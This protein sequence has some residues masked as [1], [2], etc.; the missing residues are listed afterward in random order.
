MGIKIW[1][2]WRGF[3]I[4]AI[5]FCVWNCRAAET[6]KLLWQ[7]GRTD[8]DDAEFALAPGGFGKFK[9]D[10]VFFVGES[11][12]KRDWPYAQPGPVDSWGGRRQHTFTVLFNLARGLDA[13][14]CELR[15]NLVDVRQNNPPTLRIEINGEPFDRALAP[16]NGDA[17]IRGEAKQGRPQS[18]RISFPASLLRAG[19]ND[20][21]ITTARGSWL[22]YDSVGMTA[23]AAAELTRNHVRTLLDPVRSLPVLQNKDGKLLQ[24]LLVP[25]RHFAGAVTGAIALRGEEP[26]PV[27]LT[28]GAQTIELLTLA[29]D[30]D[31]ARTL[32]L[33][34]GGQTVATQ[35][36]VLKPARKLTIYVLP[37]SHNDIGYTVI[38]TEVEKK[39]MN[40]LLLGMAAAQRTAS[41]P[42]GARFVW[43]MEV[44]WAADLFMHRMSESQRADFI[45]AVRKG[46]VV[47]N[48]S[49]ANELTGLCRPE[50]LLQLFRYSTEIAQQTGVPI[51]SAMISDVPGYTWG[52]VTAMAQAGIKYFSAAPNWFDR[53]GTIMRDCENRPFYWEAPDGKTKVLTWIPFRGYA[54]S[55][56]YQHF[57]VKLIA[58]LSD[59]LD[60]AQFPYDIVYTRWS[61]HGD[62]AAP[63]PDICD[64]IRGW[65]AKYAW[66]KFIIAGTSEAFRAFEQRYADKIP[67]RHGDWTPY[68]EDG[69]ASSALETSI[70]RANSERMVQADALWAMLDRSNYPAAG[71][72]NAW[73]N[74]L[75]YSE[76]TWGASRSITAPESKATTE[77][78]A[79]KKSYAYDADKQSRQLLE[80]PLRAAGAD[81]TQPAQLDVFNTLSW[82]RTELVTAPP[83]LSKAGDQVRDEQGNP[84]SSQRLASG[85]LVFMAA[86]VPPFACKRYTISAGAGKCEGRAIV[87]GAT[88]DNGIVRV[89]VDENTGGI[90]ELTA[91]GVEG[92][93]VDTS[94][95]QTLN[96]YL[97]L[98]GD[99]LKDIEHN[100]P[101]RV[102][103]GESGPLVA[104]LIIESDAP[105]CKKLR[106]EVRIVAGQDYVELRDL[107]D[108]ARLKATDYRVTKESVNIAFPFNVPDGDMLLDIPL[109]AMRPELDQIPG[110]CKNWFPVGRWVDVSNEREG[111]TWVTLDAPLIEIGGITA[112]LLNS[113][114]DPEIWRS[115]V[116]RTQKLYSWAMNNHW[117]TNYR[118]YQEGPT[119]FRFI[120][121]PHRQRDPAEN[122]RFARGFS[123]PLLAVPG[124]FAKNL[125][126]PLLRLSSDDVVVEALKPSD[127]GT[128]W[129]V[130]LFGAGGR[131]TSVNLWWA[132]PK[133]P[134][135]WL[136]NTSEQPLQKIDEPVT[137]PPW[138]LVTLRAQ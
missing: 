113:Q 71:F 96:D 54:M 14:E 7:I 81:E 35:D 103:V 97:Y 137:V 122:T 30:T 120:L 94:G 98:P 93:L 50:E 28:N 124:R 70:N 47:L 134:Q 119:L 75:L 110:A 64:F 9:K 20:V 92:N 25:I 63:D 78:W 24:T 45:E 68:W 38:Q 8:Q 39:Q 59:E 136:S 2:S 12:P 61:G 15:L 133:P 66:P 112:T 49:F 16:G 86:D 27:H 99:N 6:S 21:Q 1:L 106:R 26:E 121:R 76:H 53:I 91:K 77:Q 116:A 3:L 128:A 131:E 90:V 60:H 48:G 118:A 4:L 36:F 41:Y 79:I 138:G 73:S 19:E 114:T 108:K 18:V 85:E 40:N 56:I 126:N 34:V 33:R 84:V 31:T 44:L 125:S 88:L 43:N 117:G 102:S 123:Q 32:T 58:D 107:V 72:A 100:G 104:S 11:D 95:D 5:G 87:Q 57:S 23:P 127:D 101:V 22:I 62:N 46:Q 129:I 80:Q 109:G 17:S 115:K 69:A 51:D 37:H 65:N 52:T 42:E 13:G 135:L 130:R 10:G 29:V 82:P 89:R 105:G 132:T 111:I 83:E 74:I 67:R 55:H